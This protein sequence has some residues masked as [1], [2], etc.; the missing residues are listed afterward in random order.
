MWQV[1]YLEVKDK[2]FKQTKKFGEKLYKELCKL[3][4]E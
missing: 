4:E 2:V 1:L 3:Q